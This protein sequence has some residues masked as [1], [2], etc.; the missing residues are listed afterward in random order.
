MGLVWANNFTASDFSGTS[1]YQS[2]KPN[3][4]I[5]VDRVRTWFVFINDPVFDSI[6]AKIYSVNSSLEPLSLIATST[7]VR[8]KSELISLEHGYKETY[9]SFD[10]VVLQ[11]L[12][13]YAL[14]IN[15]T[16]YAPTDSSYIAWRHDYPDPIYRDPGLSYASYNINRVPYRMY[17]RSAA[18]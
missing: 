8:N 15:G 4:N 1:K 13:F 3:S 10:F 14:V 5:I 7:D 18:I 6:N 9:F 16:G 12:S 2:F 11:G 17:L